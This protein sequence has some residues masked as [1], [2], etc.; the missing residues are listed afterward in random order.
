[1]ASYEPSKRL[2]GSSI[3]G[4]F[5]FFFSGTGVLLLIKFEP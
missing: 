3:S 5:F 1:M 2:L 4:D